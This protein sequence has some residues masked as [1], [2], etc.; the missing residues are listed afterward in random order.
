M[1]L[2]IIPRYSEN[3]LFKLIHCQ[4]LLQIDASLFLI[5]IFK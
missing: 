4:Y 2:L 3:E 1:E 5:N